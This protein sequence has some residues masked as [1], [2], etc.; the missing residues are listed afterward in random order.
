MKHAAFLSLIVFL[1]ASTT[2]AA[3]PPVGATNLRAQER[4][5][6][7][8]PQDPATALPVV[9]KF[10]TPKAVPNIGCGG[11]ENGDPCIND[12]GGDGGYTAGGCNCARICYEGHTGCNLSVANNGCIAGTAPSLCRSCSCYTP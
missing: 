11:G 5:V 2:Y 12:W 7:D 9:S 6:D 10:Q 1:F 4:H 3:K 8:P